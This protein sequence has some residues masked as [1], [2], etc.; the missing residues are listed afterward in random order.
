MTPQPVQFLLYPSSLMMGN[1]VCSMHCQ[2][3]AILE[4]KFFPLAFSTFFVAGILS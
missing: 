2:V 4:P 1:C 3:S